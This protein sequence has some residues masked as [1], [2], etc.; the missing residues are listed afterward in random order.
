MD[1]PRNGH[2]LGTNGTVGKEPR[3]RE[4]AQSARSLVLSLDKV[5]CRERSVVSG[6]GERV[7]SSTG[8]VN[9]MH[10]AGRDRPGYARSASWRYSFRQEAGVAAKITAATRPIRRPRPK[11]R[12]A[13][14]RYAKVENRGG[15]CVVLPVRL[16]LTCPF[17][18]NNGA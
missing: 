12:A 18:T 14:S 13:C 4:R 2:V 8:V 7:A 11:A 10:S 5:E 15:S 1:E 6:I 17:Q 9:E 3:D 16:S